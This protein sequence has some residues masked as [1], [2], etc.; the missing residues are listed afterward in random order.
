LRTE[1]ER[2]QQVTI[3][4]KPNDEKSRSIGSEKDAS[5]QLMSKQSIKANDMNEDYDEGKKETENL[6]VI[7]ENK[8]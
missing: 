2:D 4:D 8:F 7:K 6:L 5:L 3:S 1:T